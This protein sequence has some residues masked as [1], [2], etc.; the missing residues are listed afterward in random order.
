MS[1]IDVGGTARSVVPRLI[2]SVGIT[3]LAVVA[4][5]WYGFPAAAFVILL[6]GLS[7]VYL[8]VYRGQPS[9]IAERLQTVT[10]GESDER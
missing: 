3:A 10:E 1:E 8:D 2:G 9:W 6:F 4:L 5:E 7:A